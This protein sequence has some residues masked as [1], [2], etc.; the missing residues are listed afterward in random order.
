MH[1]HLISRSA[2]RVLPVALATGSLVSVLTAAA[3]AEAAPSPAVTATPQVVCTS[4]KEGLASRLTKDITTALHGRRSTTAIALYDRTTGTKC[5]FNA[6][7][8]YDSASVVKVTV[9]GTLL[10]QAMDEHR[11]LTSREVRLSKAMITKS[12]NDATT[13]LW[14]QLGMTRIKRF[15]QLAGMTQTVPGTDGYWGLTQITATDELKLLS[16]LTSSNTV[17]TSNSRAYARD[18]MSQV[19]AS[20]RWGVPAGAPSSVTVHVKNGWLPRSTHGWRVH[21]IGAF[22][23]N[24]HDYAMAV[25]THDNST[26]DY[27]V[28]TIQA[29][30]RAVHRDLN[31]GERADARYATTPPL[32]NTPDEVIPDD[33]PRRP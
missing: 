21:S 13:S 4:D 14:K 26:M 2:R 19:V 8:K 5:T 10:R 25:L 9:L 12:D 32:P 30:A 18:L 7:K 20:Q 1:P 6:A 31:P 28:A 29:V 22:T 24:G 33:L 3:P 23:G 16:V 27:G 11:H 15:L 17:L